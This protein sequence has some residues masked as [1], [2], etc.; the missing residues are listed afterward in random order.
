MPSK[1]NKNKRKE[2][3]HCRIYASQGVRKEMSASLKRQYCYL[4]ARITAMIFILF[5]VSYANSPP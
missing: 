1:K 3:H 5:F 2:Q 4:S